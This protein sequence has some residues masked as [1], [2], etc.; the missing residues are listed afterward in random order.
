MKSAALHAI[1]VVI[2]CSF[3]LGQQYKVLWNFGSVPNDGLVPVANLISD[4]AG[5]LYG[6][7]Q[8]GGTNFF[9]D[10]I[11]GTVFELSPQSDGTWTETILY[12]FCSV[13]GLYGCLDGASPE[14][15]LIFDA[16][17]NLY[18]TTTGGGA[19]P[20]SSGYPGCGTVFELSPPSQPG[21]AWTETVL[22][23]FCTQNQGNFCLDGIRPVSQLTFD[24][25][26]NLYGT[27]SDGG[28]S[29]SPLGGGVVFELS[30]SPNG[31]TETVLYS[32]CTIATRYAC[33]N[34][35][36]PAAGVTFDKSGNLYG[37]TEFNGN[38]Q[39]GGGSIYELSPG[40]SGWT[41]TFVLNM[42][43]NSNDAG[44]EGTVVFDQM[45]NLYTTFAYAGTNGGGGVVKLDSATHKQ[46][47]FSFKNTGE[48]GPTAGPLLD[49]ARKTLYGTANGSPNTYGFVFQITA[50][51]EETTLYNFCSQSGCTDGFWPYAGL[52][53]DKAGN[54]YGTTKYGGTGTECS[55][56]GAGSCGVVFEITP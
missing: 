8:V 38:L 12:N 28:A 39:K 29:K 11:G 21:G 22:Y 5:N 33:L 16:Q 10:G 1:M 49:D 4:P 14:A 52:I 31:W 37:T 46:S 51:G 56:I 42:Q 47:N 53:E 6:T 9:P 41:G 15:G 54:L 27:A 36:Y 43:K 26:G 48:L 20:C 19:N 25:S 45:G 44:P 50:S 35:A 30:P 18:G 23:S 32:F 40:S 55:G 24:S 34:G 13:V 7:T 17:G 3:V 2:S